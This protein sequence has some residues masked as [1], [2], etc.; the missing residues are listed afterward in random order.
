LTTTVLGYVRAVEGR[1][2]RFV[3]P[4]RVEVQPV[5][6]RPPA[7]GELLVRTRWSGISGGTEMLAYRGELDPRLPRDETIGSLAGRFRYP[8]SYGYSCVGEVVTSHVDGLPEG[9][10]VFAFHPHQ[11][12]FVVRGEDT[13]SIDD[14]D[15]RVAT[16]FPLVETALQVALDAGPHLA[17]P[18]IVLGLGPVGILA[19]ALLQRGGAEVVATDP[20]ADRR[21][22]AG[23]LGVRAVDLSQ[24]GGTVEELTSGAGVPLV[25]EATGQPAALAQALELLAHEGEAI[26]C[27]WYG[28]KAVSLPLGGA[29]HRRRLRIRSS[30][31]STIPAALAGRWDVRRRRRVAAELLHD[32]PV[33]LLATDDVPFDRAAEAYAALDRGQAGMMHVAL[34]Y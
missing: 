3:A 33:K 21:E 25:V 16:L 11:D 20:R 15:G 13:V 6:V 7:D 17:E 12:V 29:F 1:A 18:V 34:R 22:A 19:A 8:F 14:V 10:M 24:I 30:Q 23:T 31:V 9:A 32:P 27:S 5:D 26:V 28:T 4:R 2:L